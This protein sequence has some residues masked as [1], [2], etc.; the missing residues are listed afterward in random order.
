VSEYSIPV[1]SI[2]THVAFDCE[3][4]QAE[5]EGLK[6]V[7]ERQRA[8]ALHIRNALAHMQKMCPEGHRVETKI[9]VTHVPDVNPV[10]RDDIRNTPTQ[11]EN[12]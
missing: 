10:L 1:S 9:V 3:A 11:G 5:R 4:R 2:D 12:R 7:A 8:T 6:G